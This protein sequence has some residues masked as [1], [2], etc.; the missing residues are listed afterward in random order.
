M[1]EIDLGDENENANGNERQGWKVMEFGLAWFW[2]LT[3]GH[4]IHLDLRHKLFDNRPAYF[5][6]AH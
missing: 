2:L 6:T 1:I 3:S 5:V 4:L